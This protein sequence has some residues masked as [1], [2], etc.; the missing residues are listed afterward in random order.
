MIKR[1]S[2]RN[3]QDKEIPEKVLKELLDVVTHAPSGGNIQ[4]I[5]VIVVQDADARK[6]LAR[7]VGDQPWVRNAPLSMI[8]CIDFYRIKKW[9]SMFDVEYEGEKAS[10]SFLI[11]YAD[12]MCSAQNVVIL[13]ESHRLAS[14][15]IGTILDVID[16]ARK[17]F[18]MPRLV[19]PM[20]VLSVGYPKTIPKDI[21]KLKREVIAHR[22]KYQL[23]SDEE[24]KQ[25]FEDKYGS[26]DD[27][28][29]RH[30][31]KIYVEAQE[32]EKQE[33]P[34]WADPEKI[35]ERIKKLNIKNNAQFLFKFR[36]PSKLM[37]RMNRSLIRS[38]KN[39]GV[40][41]F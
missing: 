40:D 41:L 19:L 16:Q 24:I 1:R 14:V 35:K 28:L 27:N 2:A 5:S 30:F 21:P 17:Y 23:M 37:I 26:F 9:A 38:F 8:F 22:E 29:E 6:E 39:A 15:Y 33:K 13:A 31:H 18:S 20:M 7:M 32:A 34:E 10:L 25:A 3:F 11:A 12:L 36:Y 4:P